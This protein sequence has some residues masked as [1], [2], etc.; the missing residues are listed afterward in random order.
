MDRI[1][2][3]KP[4][5]N[6]G[7]MLEVCHTLGRE[8]LVGNAAAID[9]GAKFPVENYQV[10]AE[11]GFLRLCVPVEYGGVGADYPT[12]GRMSEV[13]GRYCATTALTLNMHMVFVLLLGEWGAQVP[14]DEAG[15]DAV[16]RARE[17]FFPRIVNH[18]FLVGGSFSEPGA[19]FA[20]TI[21]KEGD[22]WV[23][24]GRKIFASLS[25]NANAFFTVA[26]VEGGARGD[27]LTI[28]VD[29]DAPGVSAEGEWDTL[30]MRGTVSRDL[31]FREVRVPAENVVG[32]IG[33]PFQVLI[34][35]PY[36]FG[37]SVVFPYM[38]LAQA[39]FD[40]TCNYLRG[41][42]VRGVPARSKQALKQVALA[43]MAFQ[44]ESMRALL[45]RTLDE[46]QFDP[47]K[48]LWVRALA[49]KYVVQE[50]VVDITARAIR[51]CGGRSIF[52]SLPLER[53]YR[54][55]RCAALMA[56]YGS[57]AAIEMAGKLLGGGEG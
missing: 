24:N 55:A 14:L 46:Y 32:P 57:D 33:F 38:G 29:A 27:W 13:L 45:F 50:G 49:A 1:A 11:L 15:R 40:F 28:V 2:E 53:Y 9:R 37:L 39:A 35:N 23:L 17:R 6:T 21:R 44:L 47:P 12:W 26:V 16:A 3:L 54:D 36:A 48:E 43:E 8:L 51:T 7:E 25:E 56:P 41:D 31:A 22:S 18:H 42:D 19:E 34:R 20:T 10:M 4:G 52:K 30:G 5:M